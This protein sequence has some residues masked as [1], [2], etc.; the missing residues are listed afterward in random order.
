VYAKIDRPAGLVNFVAPRSNDAVLND[1]SSDVDKLMSLIEKSCH[2]IAKVSATW[3]GILGAS[4]DAD[5]TLAAVRCALRRRR[6]YTT[7]GSSEEDLV[8]L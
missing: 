8:Q 4:G 3:R 2:L 6:L 5:R 1:W 7:S